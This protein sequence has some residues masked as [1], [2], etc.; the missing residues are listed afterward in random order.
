M[1]FCSC[2][3]IF[4]TKDLANATALSHWPAQSPPGVFG[5]PVSSSMIG[6]EA[7]TASIE[8]VQS[9][10]VRSYVDRVYPQ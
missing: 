10:V 9:L 1:T 2:P 5:V 6:I 3:I 4:V 7:D 8:W